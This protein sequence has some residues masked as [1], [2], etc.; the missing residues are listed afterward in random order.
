MAKI[1]NISLTFQQSAY[2][3]RHAGEKSNN[4]LAEGMERHFQAGLSPKEIGHLRLVMDLPPEP[5][6]PGSR[7]ASID[8]RHA[9][10]I[11]FKE[12]SDKDLATRIQRS[13]GVPTT[14]DGVA[15][16]REKIGKAAERKK[17]VRK[18]KPHKPESKKSKSNKKQLTATPRDIFETAVKQTGAKTAAAQTEQADILKPHQARRYNHG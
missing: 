18:E 15:A 10:I 13:Y 14:E 6:K 16:M 1:K 4:A 2:L 11:N 8:P 3:E 7:A 12:L 5:A 9:L 17:E